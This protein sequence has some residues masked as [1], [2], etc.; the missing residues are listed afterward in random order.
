MGRKGF[1]SQK[2]AVVKESRFSDA[3][4]W[5]LWTTRKLKPELKQE[6]NLNARLSLI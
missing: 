4:I 5:P 6:P 2:A 1:S 3:L